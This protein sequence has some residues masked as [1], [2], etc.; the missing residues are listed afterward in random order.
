MRSGVG[1][2]VKPG[3]F[4]TAAITAGEV[5]AVVP[6]ELALPVNTDNLLVSYMFFMGDLLRWFSRMRRVDEGRLSV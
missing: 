1:A 3:V 2:T 4:A 6:L 5:L